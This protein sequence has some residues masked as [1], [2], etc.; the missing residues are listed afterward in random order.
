MTSPWDSG[1][2][3][4]RAVRSLV[5]AF[6]AEDPNWR[7]WPGDK[8]TILDIGNQEDEW[9]IAVRKGVVTF[10]T[11]SRGHRQV[12][13]VFSRARD[14]WRFLIMQQGDSYRSPRR[15]PYINPRELAPGTALERVASGHRLSWPGGEATF[16]FDFAAVA[17]SWVAMAEPAD[18]AASYRH[19]NGEPLFDLGVEPGSWPPEPR[20]PLRVMAPPPVE[21]PP[22]DDLDAADLAVIDEVAARLSWQRRPSVGADIFSIG[23]NQVGRAISYRQS[24][25]VYEQTVDEDYRSAVGTFSTA[26]AA[27]RFMVAEISDIL[28][29]RTRM[30][31]V[32]PKRVGPDCAI[33]KGPT[34]FLVTSPAGQGN[35]NVGFNGHQDALTFGWI[36]TASLADIAASFQHPNGGP[37]FDL[38]DARAFHQPPKP[39]ARVGA[40]EPQPSGTDAA[41]VLTQEADTDLLADVAVID[42]LLAESLLWSRRPGYDPLVVEV[43]EFDA[44]WVLSHGGSGHDAEY[45]RQGGR[46]VYGRFSSA[47]GA[48]RFV[49]MELGRLWRQSHAVKPI[50]H[51]RP[52]PGSELRETADGYRLTWPGGEARFVQDHQAIDFSWI[53]TAEL[54]EIVASYTHPNGEPLFDLDRP[55]QAR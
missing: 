5:D 33:E 38:D 22:P 1:D 8:A 36:A 31:K 37:I 11:I 13:A 3:S 30:P 54:A 17:F 9:V 15:M 55:P 14:A 25:F 52:A 48:R 2:V 7:H 12:S 42:E 41:I 29:Q 44:E 32:T 28:R 49:V 20:R 6:L 50:S 43:A 23:D 46:T 39:S 53:A 16:H 10:E 27:R 4:D 19:V 35:F 34:G 24:Q 21:T 18:I 40:L 26:A 47:R 51:K 45:R